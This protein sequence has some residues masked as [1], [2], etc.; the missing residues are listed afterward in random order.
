M[1]FVSLLMVLY[2]THRNLH[3]PRDSTPGHPDTTFLPATLLLHTVIF[4]PAHHHNHLVRHY[5][6]SIFLDVSDIQV[7]L[8]QCNIMLCFSISCCLC[9]PC[10]SSSA[11]NSCN[12]CNSCN[13]CTALVWHSAALAH[14]RVVTLSVE[15]SLFTR[16]FEIVAGSFGLTSFGLSAA[17]YSLRAHNGFPC[18]FFSVLVYSTRRTALCHYLPVSPPTV[19]SS[20]SEKL[21]IS[22]GE[23]TTESIDAD[24]M[25]VDVGAFWDSGA[26]A[27]TAASTMAL[28]PCRCFYSSSSSLM[29][30]RRD[31]F[32]TF[33]VEGKV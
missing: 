18:R 23:S 9:S 3:T 25:A 32:L 2:T 11:C 14:V 17:P 8:P 4:A 21:R 13:S 1:C 19:S 10:K 5:L 24:A 22:A 15:Q 6:S 30:D 29:S 20:L 31:G 27:A 28:W 33:L 26:V 12:T 16:M 7:N